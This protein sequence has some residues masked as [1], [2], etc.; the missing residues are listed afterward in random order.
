MSF[1][2]QATIQSTNLSHSGFGSVS[3]VS[4]FTSNMGVSSPTANLAKFGPRALRSETRAKAKDEIK[5]VKN[6][7]KQVKKW[8]KRLVTI[9]D[10][11]LQLYKWIPIS[12]D[13]TSAENNQ[14]FTLKEQNKHPPK[15]LRFDNEIGHERKIADKS[16]N[17][18]FKFGSYNKY[19][20]ASVPN[21]GSLNHDE[22]AQDCISD[23]PIGKCNSNNYS[24]NNEELSNDYNCLSSSSSLISN[25]SLNFNSQVKDNIINYMYDSERY[26]NANVSNQNEDFIQIE[27]I[28]SNKMSAMRKIQNNIQSSDEYAYLENTNFSNEN[29]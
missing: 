20:S 17:F 16:S 12:Y 4:T 22:N 21:N 24:G 11:T 18:E 8:E 5:R 23:K 9:N 10:S 14:M 19:V 7:I 3:N 28:N 26:S 27:T 15:S 6:A 2:N 1:R 25:N 13:T 29:E